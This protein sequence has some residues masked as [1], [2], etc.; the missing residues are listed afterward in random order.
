MLTQLKPDATKDSEEAGKLT[1]VIVEETPPPR[2]SASVPHPT[3]RIDE[4]E[5]SN[6]VVEVEDKISAISDQE[7]SMEQ[8]PARINHPQIQARMAKSSLMEIECNMI[9]ATGF[10]TVRP[11]AAPQSSPSPSICL[12]ATQPFQPL[13][14]PPTATGVWMPIRCTLPTPQIVQHISQ[15]RPRMPPINCQQCVMDIQCQEEICL[16]ELVRVNLSVMLANPPPSQGQ[17]IVQTP[18]SQS[19]S[20]SEPTVIPPAADVPSLPPLPVQFQTTAGTQMN[21]E[22]TQKSVSK[23]MKKRRP[24][25]P[26]LTNNY[27]LY[28]GQEQAPKRKKTLKRK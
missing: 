2:I 1:K 8:R 14:A 21:T 16:L 17:P 23:S 7:E 20:A 11:T 13:Q 15:Y 3:A 10:G 4:S 19:L 18:G 24:K 9:I 12:T 6:Y 22:R 26:N 25:N 27:C 28:K 5:E